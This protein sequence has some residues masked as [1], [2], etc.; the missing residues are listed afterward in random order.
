MKPEP[1]TQPCS[2]P[3]CDRPARAS[4]LCWGHL[5]QK[6]RGLKLGRLNRYHRST[7]PPM[8]KEDAA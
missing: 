3:R 8:P 7:L 1:I 6:K 5:D 4:G 2:G